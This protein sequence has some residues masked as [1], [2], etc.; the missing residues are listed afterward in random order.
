[1]CE[2]GRDES[3]A[4][5]IL[6][7]VFVI[8]TGIVGVALASLAST[9]L[10]ASSTLQAKRGAEFTADAGVDAAIQLVRYS[11]TSFSQTQ[12]WQ[13]C[14]AGTLP[15][16]MN[17]TTVWVACT[18]GTAVAPAGGR[19]VEFRACGVNPGPQAN[20]T[21]AIDVTAQVVFDDQSDSGNSQPGTSV[22]IVSWQDSA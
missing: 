21:S 10:M 20:C 6:A 11:G 19:S 2:S 4:V 22:T 3:G 12:G 9:N 16:T 7:L 8:V 15:L 17:T 1:M 18:G 14:A 5:L 13:P